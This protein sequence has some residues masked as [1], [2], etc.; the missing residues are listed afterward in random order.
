MFYIMQYKY[1]NLIAISL[2]AI[3]LIIST[4][5]IQA[6]EIVSLPQ[7]KGS[8]EIVSSTESLMQEEINDLFGDDPYLGQTSYLQSP[9]SFKHE[10]K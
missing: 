7:Q 8:D 10:R 3:L 9:D 5:I 2:F 4:P 1:L 6:A